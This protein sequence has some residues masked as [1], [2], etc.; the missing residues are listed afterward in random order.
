MEKIREV[1]RVLRHKEWAEQIQECQSSG[2]HVKEW[3]RLK[4]INPNT[5]Y[6]RLRVVREEILEHAEIEKQKIVPVCVS[7]AIT[8]NTLTEVTDKS[9]NDA[10]VSISEK[11][12]IRKD[13]MEV[14]ISQNTSEETILM[15]MRGLK[16]C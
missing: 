9:R 16:Q 8:G 4:G 3:C 12:V 13:G 11:I 6:Q 2:M 1:K 10:S 5:Y 14:E 15:L 7:E